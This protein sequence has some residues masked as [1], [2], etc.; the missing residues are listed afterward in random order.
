VFS[1]ENFPLIEPEHPP[2]TLSESFSNLF[3]K[4]ERERERVRRTHTKRRRNRKET[5]PG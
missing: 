3:F 4:R 2:Y 1:G 5:S